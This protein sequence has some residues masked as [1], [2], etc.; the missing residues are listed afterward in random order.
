MTND[1]AD[2]TITTPLLFGHYKA[3]H[4]LE[5]TIAHI[6]NL[7]ANQKDSH[8][9]L[10]VAVPISFLKDLTEHYAGENITFGAEHMLSVKEGRFTAPS[11]GELLQ[12]LGAQFVLIGS[13]DERK[14]FGADESE[15]H[16]K[17][18][19]AFSSGIH[20][21]LCIGDTE[22]EF[23]EGVSKTI[24]SHQLRN[25]IADIA[26]EKITNLY[27][28]YDAPWISQGTWTTQDQAPLAA[29]KN[30]NETITEIFSPED[31]PKVKS[32]LSVPAYSTDLPKLV[33]NLPA[34]GYFLGT[35]NATSS[36]DIP[37][38]PHFGPKPIATPAQP[39]QEETIDDEE[40]PN[41]TIWEEDAEFLKDEIKE[42]NA[43]EQQVQPPEPETPE[44]K[45]NEENTP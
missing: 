2:T 22:D 21:I 24:L 15:F 13:Y 27:I 42:I 32:L 35:I 8:V 5:E 29:F 37:H 9:N 23:H 19:H 38:F 4:T 18:R 40:P 34:A 26:L 44:P 10:C 12:L 14:I 41:P 20:P 36:L 3:Y 30:F 1:T 16:Q 6:D 39:I 31:L 43:A 25:I 45:T 11:A 7:F 33:Q 28:L 17:L